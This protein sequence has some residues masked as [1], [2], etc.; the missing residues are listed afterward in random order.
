MVSVHEVDACLRRL[1]YQLTSAVTA[2]RP[3][4]HRLYGEVSTEPSDRFYTHPD[5]GYPT[6]S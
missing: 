1:T 5:K 6:L 4:R 3:I 2:G